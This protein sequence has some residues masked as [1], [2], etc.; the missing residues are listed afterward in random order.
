E[1]AQPAINKKNQAVEKITA[2]AGP[3]LSPDPAEDAR[4]KKRRLGPAPIRKEPRRTGRLLHAVAHVSSSFF[5]STKKRCSRM[6][7]AG[8]SPQSPPL[9]AAKKRNFLDHWENKKP[10]DQKYR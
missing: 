9:P 7:P 10:T 5:R 2:S 1:K 3:P 4:P 6:E 8:C